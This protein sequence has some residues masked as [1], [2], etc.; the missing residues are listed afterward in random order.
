MKNKNTTESLPS[1]K[2]TLSLYRDG[3]RGIVSDKDL[4]YYEPAADIR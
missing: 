1:H 2:K 3:T 4:T